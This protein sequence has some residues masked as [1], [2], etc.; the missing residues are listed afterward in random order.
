MAFILWCYTVITHGVTVSNE[1]LTSGAPKRFVASNASVIAIVAP[2]ANR[3]IER[4]RI[5]W[6]Q[7]KN[8]VTPHGVLN[9]VTP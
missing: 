2:C 6:V 1:L 8:A 5:R 3:V 9:G 4:Y 7:M